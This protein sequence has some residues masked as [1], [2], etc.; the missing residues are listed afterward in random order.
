GSKNHKGIDIAGSAGDAI[1]AADGGEVI[2]ADDSLSGFGLLV[3]IRHDNGDVTYYG[4][5][6]KLLV[7]VGERVYRGQKIAEMGA[8]GVASGV[9]C[10][11]ELHR[12]GKAVNPARYIDI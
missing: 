2:L 12:D 5:N 11:F 3:Q 10:H 4:H 9:H 1:Y 7:E 6:R 8:T